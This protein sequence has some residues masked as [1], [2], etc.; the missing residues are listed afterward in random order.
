M[1]DRRNFLK[2]VGGASGALLLAPLGRALGQ[3]ARREVFIGTQRA[4]TVDIH[5]H[6]VFPEVRGDPEQH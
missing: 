5:A 6:C 1:S 4:T 3:A 2:T